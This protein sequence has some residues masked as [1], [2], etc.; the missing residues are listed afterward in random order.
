MSAYE[1][2]AARRAGLSDVVLRPVQGYAEY[3]ACVALQRETWGPGFT[4]CVPAAMLMIGQKL[5]GVTAGAFSADGRLLGFVFGLTG[6]MHGRPVHWS[7]MLAVVPA[8]RGRG[9]GL[10]LKRYQ[11]EQLLTSGI[12]TVYWTFDPLV[13]RNA[14]LNVNRLG[15]EISEYVEAMYGSD[16][17]SELHSGLGTDRFIVVWHL[18]S[19]RVEA[20]LAGQPPDD[21]P[22]RDARVVRYAGRD[23]RGPGEREW[24]DD[25]AVR[26]EIPADIQTVKD[27]DVR[28]AARWRATTRRAFL[29][30]LGRGYRVRAFV[31][32][33][34]G[35]VFY[36]LERAGNG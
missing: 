17:G 12:D 34:G 3:Q 27:A 20:A 29:H 33:A 4:E 28:S 16:T 24:P 35:R 1:P 14:H 26:V 8:A 2:E 18:R 6:L 31:R 30:Y 22:F 5:G 13:A 9:L 32:D 11:R 19:P 7:D 15:A 36:G 25:D 23:P 21:A 10:R